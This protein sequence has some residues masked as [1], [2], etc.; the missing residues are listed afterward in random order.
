[1]FHVPPPRRRIAAAAMVVLAV[2][3]AGLTTP[4]G[5]M[6]P[7]SDGST[8]APA[9]ATATQQDVPAL[10]AGSRLAS[11]G[12]SGF[13]TSL[14]TPGGIVEY[15]WTRY[16]DGVTTLLP[17]G[18]YRG[19][20][21]TDFAVRSAGSVH[22]LY[23][24][25][26]GADPVTI[27]TASLGPDAQF[28]QLMGATLVMTKPDGA[29]GTEVHLVSKPA[30]TV[31]DRKVTGLPA[32][33]SIPLTATS[34]VDTLI[35]RFV[36]A[37]TT[38]QH[39]A[40]VDMATGSV[41]EDRV[42]PTARVEGAS[43]TSAT[44]VAWA[45]VADPQ[46]VTLAVARRGDTSTAPE[47]VLLGSG[48][49]QVKLL[50]EDWV[51]YGVDEIGQYHPNSLYGLTARSLTTGKTVKLLDSVRTIVPDIDGRLLVRGGT[52]E[53]G[54]GFYRIS[55]GADGTPVATLVASMDEPIVIEARVH[56]PLPEVVDLGSGDAEFWWGLNRGNTE[57]TLQ[58]THTASGK[59]WTSASQKRSSPGVSGVRWSGLFD[60]STAAYNGDYTWRMTVRPS[61]GIGPVVEQTGTLKV[62]NKPAPHDFSD[63]GS[64]DLL[65]KDSSGRLIGYDA[66]QTL[67]HTG[68]W[69]DPAKREQVDH[70]L[71]WNTYDRLSAP[72][73]IGGSV[74]ADV[75]GR[76]RSGVLWLH[77]GD[78]K[79][80]APRTKI[81]AGWQVYDRLTG[82]SDLNGDGR[83][84]LVAADK[85]GDLYLYKGTGNAAAPF[86]P[87]QKIGFG[88]GIYNQ[89]TATGNIAG[90]PAGD[91]VARDRA[92]VLW[93]YLGKGDGTFAPRIKVGAGWDRYTDIVGVGDTNRD[94]RPDLV[95]QGVMGGTHETLAHYEGTGDWRAP[96]GSRQGVYNP[97][98]L[99]TGVV[100]L[101]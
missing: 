23:D 6:T 85:A 58:L 64:P 62:A 15:R 90:A 13:L 19:G 42:L 86:A 88:W 98:E 79:S 33:A 43:S 92:G 77:T 31:L 95:V 65:V 32:N 27:D 87:R 1:M 10:P 30:D 11:A 66:R 39:L 12:A 8:A 45:E 100:T 53:H 75:L 24:L 9:A 20:N 70:G 72:G 47:R 40:L 80:F 76:D 71:G 44:H 74:H 46:Q 37:G 17:P 54:R 89:L 49:V 21:Q 101:F 29:G 36:I 38:E 59:R 94:G 67:Y 48:S 3:A 97:E 16:A 84:D 81:G 96:F 73:N 83:P 51:T 41:V 4:A 2:T 61:D 7:S 99:G 14:S 60:D 5:A 28:R 91:L 35:L 93:L 63:S 25:G 69:G 56:K 78:G 55:L 57:L 50:G 68:K 18:P 52:V 26:S 34:S 22:T 82:G